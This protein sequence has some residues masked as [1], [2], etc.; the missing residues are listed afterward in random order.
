MTPVTIL[1]IDHETYRVQ[2]LS[3]GLRIAG[4][5]VLEAETLQQALGHVSEKPSRI[6]LVIT[7][8]STRVLSNPE[9]IR[10]L[11]EKCPNIQVVVTTDFR[12][13][14][15]G[16]EAFPWQVHLLPKPFSEVELTRLVEALCL[17]TNGA[18]PGAR[19]GT[20]R[21]G[22]TRTHIKQGEGGS[23]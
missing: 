11:Q 10:I 18:E 21:F 3:R 2:S 6:D 12:P 15:Q 7:D 20:S 1:L 22:G 16:A 19:S 17:R 9:L 5:Q 14:D 13:G 8:C 4:H 23:S